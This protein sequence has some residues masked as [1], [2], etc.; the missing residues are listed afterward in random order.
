M[1]DKK[2]TEIAAE[3]SLLLQIDRVRHNVDTKVDMKAIGNVPDYI[4]SV[5][6]DANAV[7]GDL[8]PAQAYDLINKRV[9]RVEAQ[10]YLMRLEM[11]NRFNRD[12]SKVFEDPLAISS[13]G[14]RMAEMTKVDKNFGFDA[15][16]LAHGWYALERTADTSFRWMRPL[17]TAGEKRPSVAA[18]PHLGAVD[19]LIE[20]HGYALR[21]EQLERFEIR[22]AGTVAKIELLGGTAFIARLEMKAEQLGSSNYLPIE[23]FL[24]Q[25]FQPNEQDKRLLGVNV[26]RFTCRPAVQPSKRFWR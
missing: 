21:P 12:P 5:F 20:V 16:I 14:Q 24:D 8:T 1:S 3:V 4:A 18:V 25:F 10:L 17:E 22:A 23:F 13:Y 9:A 26:A 6:R 11:E 15:E 2:I 19:Q 7:S